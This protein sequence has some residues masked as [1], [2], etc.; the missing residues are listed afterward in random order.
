MLSCLHFKLIVVCCIDK[1]Y[2][3]VAKP[4]NVL[5]GPLLIK[6]ISK[7]IIIISNCD[8]TLVNSGRVTV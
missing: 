6:I 1:S 3:C 4:S 2:N 7:I 5:K 8:G